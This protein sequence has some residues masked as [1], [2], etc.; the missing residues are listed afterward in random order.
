D[1]AGDFL[2]ERPGV[3]LLADEPPEGEEPGA[4]IDDYRLVALIGEGGFGKVFLAEQE[5]PIVRRV[6]VKVVR[7]GMDSAQVIARFAAERQVLAMMAHDGIAA[8]YDAGRT[9][10]GR[11]YFVM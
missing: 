7:P 10:A 8:V 3:G 1:A 11:P 4:R 9:R 6:A 2:A 5:R